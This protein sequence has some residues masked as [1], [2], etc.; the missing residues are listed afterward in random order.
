MRKTYFLFIV[1][2]VLSAFFLSSCKVNTYAKKRKEEKATLANYIKSRNLTISTDSM[3][4]DTLKA[5]WP[6]NFY[7]KTYRGAY[8][9]ITKRNPDM[10]RATNGRTVV[11]RYIFYN[12][13][14][15]QTPIFDN[16]NTREGEYFVYT[17]NSAI[18][19]VGWNDAIPFMRHDGECEIIVESVIGTADQQT[20]VY[21]Q[22]VH[23]VSFT[24]SNN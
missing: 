2:V 14:N 21:T 4:C 15:D 3:L 8:V 23:V 12:I 19:C 24:V 13:P 22:K 18:P 5:P 20:D 16:L 1:G 7:F 11:M 6:E 10:P 9:R 17:K